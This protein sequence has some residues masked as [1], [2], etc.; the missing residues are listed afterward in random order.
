MLPVA[1][2]VKQRIEYS[3]ATV[4]RAENQA[5]KHMN[6]RKA[7]A[8]RGMRESKIVEARTV[9]AAAI[10]AVAD[11]PG[12]VKIIEETDET[13]NHVKTREQL[14][15][16]RL[17]NPL[18]LRKKGMTSTNTA[19]QQLELWRFG[20]MNELASIT[21]TCWVKKG[22]KRCIKQACRGQ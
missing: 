10:E 8:L 6:A 1:R 18:T 9:V 19:K 21:S 4:L 5:T 22:K 11:Q 14:I 15:R 13:R 12:E 3:A 16:I 7:M 17:T 2:L 20:W